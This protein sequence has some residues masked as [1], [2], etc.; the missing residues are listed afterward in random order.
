MMVATRLAAAI[1]LVSA[2]GALAA[3]S[4]G[5]QLDKAG[6]PGGPLTL[7]LGTVNP[8]GRPESAAIERFAA[9]VKRLSGGSI[10]VRI[11]WAAA[12]DSGTEQSV[13]QLLREGKFDA[14][15]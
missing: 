12:G 1:L 8:A 13:A 4:G 2:A 11:V 9:A 15:V 5:G 3:C 14:A 6:G 7:S 10:R